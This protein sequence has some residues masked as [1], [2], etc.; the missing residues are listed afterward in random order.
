MRNTANPFAQAPAPVQMT[1][2]ARHDQL[3]IIELR[4]EEWA[5]ALTRPLSPV[6][7]HLVALLDDAQLEATQA[8]VYEIAPQALVRLHPLAAIDWVSQV[9]KDFPP[10]A[11]GRFYVHGSHAPA[12]ARHRHALR[13]DAVAAFGTGEHATT[14]G[15]LIALQRLAR[16]RPA[17][18]LRD[19]VLLDIGSGTGILA[20]G[21]ARLWPTARLVATDIDPVAV[22]VTATN[23]RVNGVASR[24]RALVS[25]GYRQ[26]HLRRLPRAPLIVANILARP[27]MRMAAD[28]ARQLA[29]GGVIVLS[30]LLQSQERMVL[31]AYAAQGLR[32]SFRLRREGWSVLVLRR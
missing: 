19:R 29:P 26:R 8:L 7:P 32:L 3:D 18:G 9:Q 15:C 1:I 13:I 12:P 28:A 5:L 25:D 23:L 20:I 27:L 2:E 17:R 24:A 6:V 31:A 22:A 14:A 11:L 30:G 21:A 10:F 16:L 4:L